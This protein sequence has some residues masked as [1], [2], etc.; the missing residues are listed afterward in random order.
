MTSQESFLDWPTDETELLGLREA[1][2]RGDVPHA[3]LLLG[4][5]DTT[6]KFIEYLA[7]TLLCLSEQKPCGHCV[8][9]KRF[10][11]NSHPDFVEVDTADSGRLKTAD[12]ESL[13]HRLKM[14][15]HHGGK[16][17]Y[18][19]YHMETATPISS[20]RLLKTLE[21]PN[22]N[23][24][25]LLAAPHIS[26]VLPTVLSRCFTYRI[27]QAQ[28]GFADDTTRVLLEGFPESVNHTFAAVFTPMVEWTERFFANRVP[29]ILLADEWVKHMKD[30]DAGESLHILSIW[31]RDLMHIALGNRR[32]IHF[33][34]SYDT[35]AGQAMHTTPSQ[36]ARAI[37]LVLGARMRLKSNVQVQL[38]MEQLCIR[39][40]EVIHDV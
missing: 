23:V 18:A 9:C 17:V 40:Q 2:L 12:I 35:L 29:P 10:D 31:F 39:L 28:S 11:A 24:I 4:A 25:A 26:S 14:R 3:I 33:H 5:V 21:E 36:M 8:A 15:A 16:L 37:E 13:Q 6:T 22:P 38:N 19:I 32:D 1:I 27:G 20:N 34:A 7:K 30:V